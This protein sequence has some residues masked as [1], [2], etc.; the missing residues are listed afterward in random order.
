[1]LTEVCKEILSIVKK[2]SP[3]AVQKQSDEFEKLYNVLPCQNM[4]QLKEFEKKISKAETRLL[5]VIIYFDDDIYLSIFAVHFFQVAKLQK[6]NKSSDL[7]QFVNSILRKI[8]TD[9]MALK[10]NIKGTK[11]VKTGEVS[12]LAYS[13]FRFPNLVEGIISN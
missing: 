9:P 4:T 3:E 11:D 7:V 1:V 13:H 12:K 8:M 2:L 10:F 5:L 6:E